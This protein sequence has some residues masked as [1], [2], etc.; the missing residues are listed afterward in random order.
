MARKMGNACRFAST[1][2][3]TAGH[4]EAESVADFITDNDWMKEPAIGG[5]K[6]KEK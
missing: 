3:H 6:R 1:K 4:K 5:G 2:T